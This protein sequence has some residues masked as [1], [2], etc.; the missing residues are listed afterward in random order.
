MSRLLLCILLVSAA[1]CQ[2]SSDTILVGAKEFPEQAILAHMVRGLIES[3]DGANAEVVECGDTFTCQQALRS[4][5]IDVMVEYSG[6]GSLY[7]GARAPGQK[8]AWPQLRQHY[9]Q[10]GLEWLEPLGFDNGYLLVV[11]RS[12][13]LSAQSI[14]DLADVEGGVR[15]ACP[16]SYLRRP[17]DG[18]AAL[19]RR[20]GLR[21]RGEPVVIERSFERLQALFQGRADVAVVYATD[22]ALPSFEVATLT[23][24]LDFFPSYEAAVLISEDALARLPGTRG[25]LNEL[26]GTL[27]TDT[28]RA[29]NYEVDVE[30]WS[31]QVVAH[32]FLELRNWAPKRMKQGVKPAV[33][34]A[35]AE[36]DALDAFT[37][38]AAR[39]VRQALPDSSVSVEQVA[40]PMRRVR[41]GAARLAVVG[42]ERFFPS[43]DRRPIGDIEAIAVVGARTMLVIRRADD[44]GPALAGRVGVAEGPSGSG[45]AARALLGEHGVAA[46]TA[47]PPAVLFGQVRSGDLDAALILVEAGD[48]IVTETLAAGG[49]HL[50]DVPPP[51]GQTPYLRPARIPANTYAG[52]SE[53]IASVSV[54]V[55]VAGPGRNTAD[56]LADG[57]LGAFGS[58]NMPLS[59][60]QAER[61][62]DAT[63]VGETPDPVLPS[64]WTGWAPSAGP[65]HGGEDGR[66]TDLI[67]NGA[68]VLFLVWLVASVIRRE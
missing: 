51:S 67:L 23:D 28:M 1:A 44:D 61:L 48:E 54:Q 56:V 52:Q 58:P 62:V 2:R 29:L 39:A 22:A 3:S 9:R 42:A 24:S 26:S 32:R 33:V 57:P 6:T 43:S 34:V 27:D 11:P 16:P 14:S 47:A 38:R 65:A 20:H 5:R 49:L 18:M 15:I 66:V 59:S 17:G 10:F 40:D 50:V 31:P 37:S 12:S 19:V 60:E 53:P 36:S 63:G 30:G 25:R 64:L 45:R 13:P 4:G 41:T 21:M 8:I 46:A 55:L 35:V 7:S 68:A